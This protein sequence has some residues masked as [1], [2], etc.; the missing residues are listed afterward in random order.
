MNQKV[1]WFCISGIFISA[2][3]IGYLINKITLSQDA[4][5]IGVEIFLLLFG[6]TLCNLY[7]R[8]LV[9]K[10]SFDE[11]RRGV[12]IIVALPCL[13]SLFWDQSEFVNS[14]KLIVLY[15][16]IYLNL[17]LSFFGISF[18]LLDTKN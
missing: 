7:T 3:E 8:L 4:Y 17:V 1:F 10:M 15:F 11:Y 14:L 12:A 18:N 2:F 9:H 13:A 5:V 16:M 6:W